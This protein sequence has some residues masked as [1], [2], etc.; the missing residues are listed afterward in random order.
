MTAEF[1][2]KKGGIHLV[3]ERSQLKASIS[4]ILRLTPW[5]RGVRQGSKEQ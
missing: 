2:S 5:Y 4:G 3:T 1:F